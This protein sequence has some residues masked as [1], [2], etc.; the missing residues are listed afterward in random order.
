MLHSHGP[1][2]LPGPPPGMAATLLALPGALP[3]VC[4]LQPILV[5]PMSVTAFAVF[6]TLPLMTASI[7]V[8]FTLLECNTAFIKLNSLSVHCA[9]VQHSRR[10]SIQTPYISYKAEGRDVTSQ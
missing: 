3:V 10:T 8:I 9:E 6:L 2:S 4:P 5:R 7:C 1:E